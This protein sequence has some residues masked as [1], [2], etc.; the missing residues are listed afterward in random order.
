MLIDPSSQAR[1]TIGVSLKMY[2]GHARTLAWSREIADLART[3]EAVTSGLVDLFVIPTFPCLVECRGIFAGTRVHLGAQ[4]VA[5]ADAG[6]FTGEVSAAE[7]A[8][9]GCS[10]TEIAH[11]ERRALFGE[12]D[13][14][15][16][17]KVQATLRHG[18]TPLICVGEK[19]DRGAE[20]AVA[21]VAGQLDRAIPRDADAH[22][23]IVAAYE[24]V[25]AIGAL[26][27]ASEEFIISVL[28]GIG[29]YL[30][31]RPELAGSRVIYGGSAGPGLLTR[32]AG[33]IRGLF[34]GRFAHDAAAVGRILDEAVALSRI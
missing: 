30:S 4:D 12:T 1:F 17:G 11:A 31:S 21:E 34:L 32:G 28:A 9:V 27:P 29:E 13:E 15:I 10:L 16:A 5:W 33:G 6:A 20:A 14:M 23:A 24:P 26:A 19:E 22:G 7:L 18:L 2:F 3:H 25:W 8:E